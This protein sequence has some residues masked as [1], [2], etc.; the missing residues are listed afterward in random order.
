MTLEEIAELA[1]KLK[2]WQVLLVL[3]VCSPF[4]ANLWADLPMSQAIVL[5][6]GLIGIAVIVRYFPPPE[7]KKNGVPKISIS[8]AQTGFCSQF[9]GWTSFED[10]VAESGPEDDKKLAEIKT[11]VKELRIEIGTVQ[12][13]LERTF[14]DGEHYVRWHKAN[15]KTAFLPPE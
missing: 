11:K 3:A 14:K 6:A 5:F 10:A 8:A 15:D 4:A 12:G 9:T 7:S 1:Q 2:L 13:L